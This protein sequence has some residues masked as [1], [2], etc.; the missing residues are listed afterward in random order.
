MS[1]YELLY[2][3]PSRVKEPDQTRAAISKILQTK[4]AEIWVEKDFGKRRLAYAIDH[5][6]NGQYVGV[7]FQA[8]GPVLSEVK[9]ALNVF[10][11]ILRFQIVKISNLSDKNNIKT[12]MLRVEPSMMASE[13]PK[14]IA[15]YA[16]PA[17]RIVVPAPQR[18]I[19][20]TPGVVPQPQKPMEQT[21]TTPAE[22]KAE[23]KIQETEPTKVKKDPKVALEDLDK[24]LEEILDEQI[25]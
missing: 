4:G 20:E 13:Q 19:L 7:E 25:K 5:V 12:D 1:P 22:A 9:N 18:D 6:R 23:E 24:K 2:I 17:P 10:D 14:P 11:D 21:V 8:E 16:A 3:I 15:A